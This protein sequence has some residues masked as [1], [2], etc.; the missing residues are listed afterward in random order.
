MKI[1]LL[2]FA[3]AST[4]HVGVTG[5]FRFQMYSYLF[6]SQIGHT[7]RGDLRWPRVVNN[8][9]SLIA[10]SVNSLNNIFLLSAGDMHSTVCAI[11]T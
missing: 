8:F 3:D 5:D 6:V 2:T 9:I 4:L 1:K 11:T 10:N 7:K